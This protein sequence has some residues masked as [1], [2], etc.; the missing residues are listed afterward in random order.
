MKDPTYYNILRHCGGT[1]TLLRAYE[2]D[3]NEKY[4]TASRKSID[5]FISTIHEQ[6]YKNR[7]A[8]YPLFNKKSKLGGAGIGLV[9][10]VLYYQ[11]SGDDSY[12]SYVEGLVQ[13]I[14]SRI[15]DDGEMIGYFIHPGFRNSAE[16]HEPTDDEKKSL[17]LCQVSGHNSRGTG[18]YLS[19]SQ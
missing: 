12:N 10:L 4:L 1:I 7:H 11:L 15:S 13:H 17:F 16:I 9:S 8:C 14:L 3:K 2:L 19:C 5:F 18:H 6:K